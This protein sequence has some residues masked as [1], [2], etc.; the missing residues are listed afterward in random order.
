MTKKT[1]AQWVTN[2]LIKR[3]KVSRNQ[4]LKMYISRLGCY[5]HELRNAGFEISG[6]YVNKNGGKDYVYFL[7]R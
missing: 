1:Q 2:E 3:G 4:A 5:I 7:K 6:G